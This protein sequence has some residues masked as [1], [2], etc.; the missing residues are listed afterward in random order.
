MRHVTISIVTRDDHR[1]STF[2]AFRSRVSGD[3][4]GLSVEFAVPSLQRELVGTHLLALAYWVAFRMC[5]LSVESAD[6]LI[7]W[8]KSVLTTV[9]SP[10][11]TAHRVVCLLL[12][13][14]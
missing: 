9:V 14:R 13:Y 3:E 10:R 8:R 1:S 6:W 7:E 12:Y 11:G 5:E 2:V 4:I